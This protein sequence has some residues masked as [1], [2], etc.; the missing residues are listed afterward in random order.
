MNLLCK[1]SMVGSSS[2]N[3]NITYDGDV[4]IFHGWV[5]PQNID[6][7]S[8]LLLVLSCSIHSS[9]VNFPGV[10]SGYHVVSCTPR[11]YGSQIC[12]PPKNGW[13]YP[14]NENFVG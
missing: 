1:S 4:L 8:V 13:F 11:R 14:D 12:V 6:N 10:S 7:E 2:F 3:G 5:T 9:F